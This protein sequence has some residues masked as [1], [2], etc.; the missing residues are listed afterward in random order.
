ML[1]MSRSL[2]FEG[3]CYQFLRNSGRRT[4]HFTWICPKPDKEKP[5]GLT[6]PAY[7]SSNRRI[8]YLPGFS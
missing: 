4:A 5:G 1:S 2:S 8:G 3:G 6:H 7:I